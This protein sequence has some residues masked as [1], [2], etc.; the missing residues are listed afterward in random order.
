MI[1]PDGRALLSAIGGELAEVRAMVDDLSLLASDMI[2]RCPPQF[3]AEAIARAQGF[4]LVI[5]RLDVLGR[6]M[7]DIGSGTPPETALQGISLSDIADR[8]TGRGAGTIAPS[9]DLVLFD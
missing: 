6:L 9:G 1:Q 5:Q 4:D 3:C 7:A 2:A 8:L